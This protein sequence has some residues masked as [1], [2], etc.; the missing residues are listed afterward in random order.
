MKTKNK[1]L[2]T[3]SCQGLRRY[4]QT[5]TDGEYELIVKGRKALIYCHGMNTSQ[6]KE[7]VSLKG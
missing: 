3:G 7:Y 2:I 1:Y 4:N 5:S 6:P